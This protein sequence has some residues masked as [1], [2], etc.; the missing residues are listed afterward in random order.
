MDQDWTYQDGDFSEDMPFVEVQLGP[1]D[2]Y[3]VYDSVRFRYEKWSGGHP[4]EQARLAYLKDFLYR[5]VL[6]YKYN[7]D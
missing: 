4:D 5:I 2:L 6:E 3:L 1:E 7:M